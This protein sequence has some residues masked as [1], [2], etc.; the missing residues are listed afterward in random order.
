ML[1]RLIANVPK[2]SSKNIL[3]KISL[4]CEEGNSSQQTFVD[5]KYTVFYQYLLFCN[6]SSISS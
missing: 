1:L 2:V 4:Q 3:L 5:H 6:E